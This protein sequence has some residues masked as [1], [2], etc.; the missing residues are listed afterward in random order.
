MTHHST[1]VSRTGV[2]SSMLDPLLSFYKFETRTSY[3]SPLNLH[4][5]SCSNLLIVSFTASRFSD[6]TAFSII[7][8]YLISFLRLLFE[9][10]SSILSWTV[11]AGFYDIRTLHHLSTCIMHLETYFDKSVDEAASCLVMFLSCILLFIP[12]LLIYLLLE[13]AAD[14]VI[15]D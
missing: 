7:F 11:T 9:V 13:I 2:K 8:D 1:I 10:F 15:T 4:I 5:S 3:R 14:S 6:V 12:F